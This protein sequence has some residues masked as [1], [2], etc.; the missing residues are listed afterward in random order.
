MNVSPGL[1]NTVIVF[2]IAAAVH[3]VPGGGDTADI[4]GALLSTAIIISIVLIGARVYRERRTD[5]M[6]L[7]ERFRGMLYGA[8][9]LAIFAM[10]ARERLWDT[11]PGLLLWFAMIGGASY[12]LVLVWQHYRSYSF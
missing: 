1:R 4:V 10:A 9:G 3:F 5:I 7:E 11:G 2:A 12:A 8:I 6:G